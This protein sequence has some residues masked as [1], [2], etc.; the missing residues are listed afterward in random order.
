MRGVEPVDE[1]FMSHA[2]ELARRA[3]GRTHPNPLV[4]A[5]IV[6]QGKVIAEGWHQAAG[7]PHAEI[8]ALSGLSGPVGADATL[9]VTLEPCSTCGRTGACTDAIIKSGIRRVVVGAEDPNPKHAGRGFEVLRAAGIEV[10][11]GVL[12]EDCADLNLAFN[13]WIVNQRP[14]LAAKLAM[15]LDGKFAAASGH[16]RW[17]TGEAARANVME[18]RRYFPAIA[19]GAQTVVEDNP[20]L[21]SRVGDQVFCP[22]RFVFDRHLKTARLDPLPRLFTD[23]HR[24]S[25]TVL[26]LQ[27]ADEGL[28]VKLIQAGIEVWEL[29]DEGGHLSWEAFVERCAREEILG[30]YI[31]AG[32][33]LA[34][35]LIEAGRIDYLF[36]YQAPK[37]MS[38]AAARGIGSERQTSEMSQAIRMMEVRHEIFGTDILTR[39]RL[40][41]R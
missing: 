41:K 28:K 5:I 12:S 36:V 20:S 16:S 33:R 8:E 19:V 27:S 17:V 21:T 11:T 40:E 15:T 1:R 7:M 37:F 25:T 30:V 13:H 18:W 9:Y 14:L 31:E 4:G 24:A 38:D 6:E 32:P 26:C 2:V 23:T 10:V 22:K 35:E 3:W 34:T 29:P 39:G